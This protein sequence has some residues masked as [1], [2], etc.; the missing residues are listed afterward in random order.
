MSG[1]GQLEGTGRETRATSNTING[2]GLKTVN[3]WQWAGVNEPRPKLTG[4]VF[5]PV[6]NNSCS[7]RNT[8]EEDSHLNNP[9]D[10]SLT[11]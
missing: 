11:S 2:G 9:V 3:V 4:S 1:D 6:S 8:V 10:H 7:V 5:R